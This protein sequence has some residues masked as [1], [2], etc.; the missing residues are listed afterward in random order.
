MEGGK[1]KDKYFLIL[2]LNCCIPKSLQKHFIKGSL[3]RFFFFFSSL[4][5]PNDYVN[6]YIDVV[7]KL[8]TMSVRRLLRDRGKLLLSTFPLSNDLILET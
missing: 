5:L 6:N 1:K 4:F 7:T 8:I 3:L 2:S